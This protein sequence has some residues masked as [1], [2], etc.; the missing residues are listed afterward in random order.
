[1]KANRY[2]THVKNLKDAREPLRRFFA[3]ARLLDEYLGPILYQLPPR[4]LHRQ[5]LES[6]LDLL[7]VDMLH[8]FGFRD[9]RWMVEEELLLLEERGFSFC[10]HNFPGLE[11]PR[12]AEGPIAYVRFHGTGSKYHVSYGEAALRG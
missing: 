5:R 11:V 6:F 1:V 3:R 12:R 2:L 4:Y 7:P 9:Q 10:A 8:V